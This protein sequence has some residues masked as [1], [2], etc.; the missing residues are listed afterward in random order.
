MCSIRAHVPIRRYAD[1]PTRP[2][3]LLAPSPRPVDKKLKGLQS[4]FMTLNLGRVFRRSWAP[5]A[6]GAAALALVTVICVQLQ[7]IAS[8]AALLYMVV[9]VL[10]SLQGRF[11]P[12]IFVSLVAIGCLDYCFVKPGA[13]IAWTGA[14]DLAALVA[15]LTIAIVI[16]TLLTKVRKSFR[17]LQRSEARLA[18]G[19]RLSRTGSWAWNVSNQDNVYWSAG[20]FRIFG[21]EPGKEPVPYQKALQRIHPDDVG[22]FEKYLSQVIREKQ[23]WEYGFRLIVPGEQT[24]YVRTIGRPVSD[25]S[26]NLVEYVGTVMDVTEQHHSTAALQKAFAEVNNLNAELTRSNERL[27]QEIHEREEAEE[28]LRI[29]EQQRAT[30]LAKANEA[31]RS[32]LDTLADVPELDDFLGQV[33]ASISRYLGAQFSTVRLLNSERNRLTVELVFKDDVVISPIEAG[34]P[35]AWRSVPP[36]ENHLAIYQNQ[37][38][39]VTHPFDPNSPTPPGLREY[40]IELGMKTGL[41]IPLL[42]GGEM[43][44]LLAFYFHEEC[45]F[46]PEELEIARALATQAGLAVHLTRLARTAKQTAVLEERNRLAGEIHDSLAQIFAGISMQLFASMEGLSAEDND[47]RGFIER[48]NELAHFGLAEARRS[49]LSLRSDIIEEVGLVQALQMLVERSNIPG[50]LRCNFSAKGFTDELPLS[51][52]QGLLR[53]AQEAISNALRHAKPTIVS[54]SLKGDATLATLEIRD[55]GLGIDSI[56]LETAEGLG[57]TSMRDRAKQLDAQLD[58]RSAPGHGTTVTVRLPLSVISEK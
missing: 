43:H 6:I 37:P 49:A 7:A 18:E 36:N 38:V 2:H 29:S 33:M 39:T 55:N 10:I 26:G 15:Y 51:A 35:E 19:E 14:L 31:L 58:I 4:S 47:S 1:T 30:H 53:I 23:D 44:G 32:C 5:S 52:Q 16:T 57:I 46:D 48:A 42:S 27:L 25:E 41:I 22:V 40:L 13:R 54:V 56:H 45:D 50:R 17:D 20:Q 28:A 21:F 34:F 3:A 8:V 12:A 11:V 9:V 24:K